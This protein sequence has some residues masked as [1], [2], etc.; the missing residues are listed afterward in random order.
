MLCLSLTPSLLPRPWFLQGLVSGVLAAAGYLIGVFCGHLVYWLT[1]RHL[2]ERHRRAAW[3]VLGAASAGLIPTFM[4]LA[5][6]WQGHLHALMGTSPPSLIYSLMIPPEAIAVFLALVFVVRLLITAKRALGRLLSRWVPALAARMLAVAGTFLLTVALLQGVVA[7]GLMTVA[8]TG[9]EFRNGRTPAGATAPA[10]P[11]MSGG[12]GSLVSWDALGRYGGAFVTNGPSVRQ[13]SRFSGV[14]AR[15]PI[16]VYV[17]MDSA[18]D[19]QAKAALA[20]REL[21]RTGAFSRKVLNVITATGM[22]WI[23]RDAVDPLE[24]M[25]NGDTAQ[26][27]IQYSYLPSVMSFVADRDRAQEAGRALFEQVHAE[28]SRLPRESRPKLLVFGESLGAFGAE[29]TFSGVA[30]IRHRTDGML[31]IGPPNNSPLWSRFTEHRDAG[32]PERLPTYQ[33]GRTVRFAGRPADLTAPGPDWTSPRVVYLQH[34]SDPVVWWSPRLILHQPDWMKEPLGRDVDPW[35]DWYP[36]VTFAQLTAD[37]ILSVKA[38][39]GHGHSYDDESA[40]AWAQIVPPPGWSA[41]RTAAL[42][43]L[44]AD[45]D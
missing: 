31:L 35:I 25:Y 8:N 40:A 13:L 18:P 6:L 17:G 12:P 1:R 44:I 24:Y 10:V 23:D 28:W 11:E 15:Q 7:N 20:V 2:A 4:V 19:I 43:A 38:P 42:T 16:R 32:T 27:A 41:A 26:V 22:G 5:T 21:K 33:G 37:L 9:F 45:R 14:P 3:W 39:P 34:P 36:L 30:D 29:S